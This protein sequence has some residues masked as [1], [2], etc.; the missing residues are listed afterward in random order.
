MRTAKRRTY[1]N[2]DILGGSKEPVD[3]NAHEG[4]VK[5]VL[6]WQVRETRVGHSLGDDDGANGDAFMNQLVYIQY[7][8]IGVIDVS[9]AYIDIIHII[10]H[11]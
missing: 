9:F 8:V 2:G 7:I 11:S 6:D 5:A 3:E 1:A 10:A 4:R